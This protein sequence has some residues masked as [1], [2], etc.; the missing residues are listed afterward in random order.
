[1]KTYV[2]MAAAAMLLFGGCATEQPRP[3]HR[4]SVVNVLDAECGND[5][6]VVKDIKGKRRKDGFMQV[7]VQGENTSGDYKRLEYRI[8]WYDKSG[9]QLDTILSNW[10]TVPAYAHQPFVIN[11]VSPSTRARKFRIYIRNEKEMLCDKQE[12]EQ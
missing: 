2:S 10:T 3:K 4:D 7:Q 6:I 1:M 12:D 9:F 5:D 11:T 8:I